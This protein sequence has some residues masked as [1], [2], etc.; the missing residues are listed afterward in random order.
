MRRFQSNQNQD[1]DTSK[2]GLVFSAGLVHRLLQSKT[3]YRF[4]RFVP[5]YLAAVLEYVSAEILE[6]GGNCVIEIHKHIIEPKHLIL[7]IKSDKELS[8]LLD[9][10]LMKLSNK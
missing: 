1:S 10:V 4:E 8:D 7:G 5:I 6:L 9:S 2:A 3:T